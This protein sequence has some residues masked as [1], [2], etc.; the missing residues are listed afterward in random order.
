MNESIRADA[1]RVR[2]DRVRE[3]LCHAKYDGNVSKH[4]SDRFDQDGHDT[5]IFLAMFDAAIAHTVV[6]YWG[7]G[8]G[9]LGQPIMLREWILHTTEGDNDDG[10]PHYERPDA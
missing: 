5:E 4:D 6:G 3:A 7:D 1:K 2:L 10:S 9:G 8:R